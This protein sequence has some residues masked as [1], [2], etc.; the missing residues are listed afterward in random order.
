MG[1]RLGQVALLPAAGQE[2]SGLAGGGQV[3]AAAGRGQGQVPLPAQEDSR[4]GESSLA[5]VP[6]CVTCHC[7]A[8]TANCEMRSLLMLCRLDDLEKNGR[9]RSYLR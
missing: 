7:C 9:G 6:S 4:P 8:L 5:Y 2:V 3:Q 1:I